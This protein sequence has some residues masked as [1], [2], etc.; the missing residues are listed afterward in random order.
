V[1]FRNLKREENSEYK[2]EISPCRLK[3]LSWVEK[4]SQTKEECLKLEHLFVCG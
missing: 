2:R 3:E 1:Q 4:F